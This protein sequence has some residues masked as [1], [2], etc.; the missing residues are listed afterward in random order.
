MLAA[1]RLGF[2]GVPEI[3]LQLLQWN[4]RLLFSPEVKPRMAR[5]RSQSV[6]NAV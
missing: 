3:R 1:S 6:G 4:F 2:R 5:L